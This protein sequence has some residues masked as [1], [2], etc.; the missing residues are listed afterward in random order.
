MVNITAGPSGEIIATPT[1]GPPVTYNPG[2]LAWV[3]VASGLVMIAYSDG[4][5]PSP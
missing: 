4:K 1:D 3:L 2:D 5:M